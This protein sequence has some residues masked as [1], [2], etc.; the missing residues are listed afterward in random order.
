MRNLQVWQFNTKAKALAAE[1]TQ[2]LKVK[3]GDTVNEGTVLLLLEGEG[4]AAA[5]PSPVPAAPAVAAAPVASGLKH[6]F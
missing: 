5:A 2:E 3:I 4:G 1:V 6:S